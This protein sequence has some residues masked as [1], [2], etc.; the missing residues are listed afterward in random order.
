MRAL[1]PIA[2]ILILFPFISIGSSHFMD[3]EIEVGISVLDTH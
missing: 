2:F 1:Y 3:D